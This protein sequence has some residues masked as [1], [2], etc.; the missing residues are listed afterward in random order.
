MIKNFDLVVHIVIHVIDFDYP[1][2]LYSSYVYIDLMLMQL[3]LGYIVHLNIIHAFYIYL[4]IYVE[5]SM[6]V[7]INYTIFLVN[8]LV[9]M[10]L[11]KI[12]IN[13]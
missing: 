1:L 9:M 8:I 5:Y 6:Y 3:H 7:D 10:S 2:T 12:N 4:T 13:I 11:L